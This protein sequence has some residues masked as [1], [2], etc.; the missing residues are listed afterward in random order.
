MLCLDIDVST[1]VVGYAT[2]Y[3]AILIVGMGTHECD[4]GVFPVPFVLSVVSSPHVK[5][6]PLSVCLYLPCVYVSIA[7]D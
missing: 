5:F 7:A 4:I 1:C 2:C 3:N 6:L